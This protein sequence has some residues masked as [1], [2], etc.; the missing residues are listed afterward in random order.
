MRQAGIGGAVRIPRGRVHRQY[1]KG[2]GHLRGSG[3]D[4]A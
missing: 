1:R 2:L 3:E 4:A